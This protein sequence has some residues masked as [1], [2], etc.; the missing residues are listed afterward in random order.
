MA[1]CSL[2]CWS[3]LT[4]PAFFIFWHF[5]SFNTCLIAVYDKQVQLENFIANFLVNIQKLAFISMQS[6]LILG[7]YTYWCN[8]HY[9]K[10]GKVP[11]L[12]KT[13]WCPPCPLISSNY[14]SALFT[15]GVTVYYLCGDWLLWFWLLLI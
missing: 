12:L 3:Y 9:L 13:Q 14:W 4:T 11:L 8:H 2:R 7:I 1:N 15:I 5:S 6:S 10:C